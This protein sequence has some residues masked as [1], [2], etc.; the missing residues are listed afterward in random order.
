MITPTDVVR[1]EQEIGNYWLT[2]VRDNKSEQEIGPVKI[3]VRC[4]YIAQRFY[5]KNTFC[6][7]VPLVHG[8]EKVSYFISGC[9]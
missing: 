3:K 6:F 5:I 8:M 4:L 7:L 9:Q 2:N 1:N